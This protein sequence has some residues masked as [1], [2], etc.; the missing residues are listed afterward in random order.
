MESQAIRVDGNA[1]AGMLG[2]IFVDEMTAARVACGGCGNI[3]PIGAQHAYIHAPGAVL[4]CCHCEEVLFV[5]TPAGENHV[6]GLGRAS[7]LEAT[8][9]L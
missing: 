9:S 8:G 3:E 1:M 4:R 7:W 5:L 2:E 6:L